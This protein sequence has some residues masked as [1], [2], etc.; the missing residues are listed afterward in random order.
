[1][2]IMFKYWGNI[3]FK[4]EKTQKNDNYYETLFVLD[5][6]KTNE[7]VKQKLLPHYYFPNMI[8]NK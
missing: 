3:K 1:M 6:K 4:F 7:E 8:I 5:K 2:N